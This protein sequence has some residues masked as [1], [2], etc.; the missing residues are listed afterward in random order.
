LYWIWDMKLF[1][2]WFE[3]EMREGDTKW[4]LT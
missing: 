2:L 4:D 3:L 1:N